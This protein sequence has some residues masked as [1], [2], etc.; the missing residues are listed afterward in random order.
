MYRIFFQRKVFKE[1]K[2]NKLLFFKIEKYLQYIRKLDNKRKREE[3]PKSSLAVKSEE[4]RISKLEESIKDL[5]VTVRDIQR[6]IAELAVFTDSQETEKS[7][8]ES[9]W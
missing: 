7:E 9:E 4:C 3:L 6:E 1:F 2:I 5:W 8:S